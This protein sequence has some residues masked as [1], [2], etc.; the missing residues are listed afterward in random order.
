MNPVHFGIMM[1]VN[2]NI[3][4]ITPP[5]GACLFIAC[6]VAKLKLEEVVKEI[7]PFIIAEVVALLLITFI[8]DLCLAIPRWM[9][10]MG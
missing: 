8:P 7:W 2:L 1:C 5:L 3:G 10:L 9:G 6:G 4:L